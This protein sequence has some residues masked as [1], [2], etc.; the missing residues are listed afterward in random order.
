MSRFNTLK[1]PEVAKTTHTHQGGVGY[2]YKP[3]FELIALLSTGLGDK[4]YEK[5]DERVKRLIDIISQIKDK[6]FVAKALIYA[7]SVIGQRSVTHLGAVILAKY[8]SGTDLATRFF[9]KRTRK[10]NKGGVI[11]RLDDILEI[12]ACYTLLN[13]STKK[14]A[15][16]KLTVNLPNSMKKGFKKAL[17][18]ADE[19]ELARYQG[20][21]K[22]FSM[23][24]VVNLVHPTPSKEMAKVFKALMDGTLK[25]SNTVE[26]K[27]SATGQIV[28]TKLKTGEITKEEA[29]QELEEVKLDN[30]LELIRGRKI[31]YIALIR[32]L[33]NIIVNNPSKELINDTCTLLTDQKMIKQ[34]LI[35]PHQIDI[36]TEVLL[37]EF[38]PN[39]IK[40]LLEALN[41]AY[42]LAI[43]NLVELFQHG[44]TAVVIDTSGSM[45]GGATVK[46]GGKSINKE[47]IEK[48]ALIGATLAKGA[49][50]DLYQFSSTCADIK[51]NP[52]DTV[53]SIKNICLSRQGEV[54]H[55]TNFGEIFKR[56]GVTSGYDRIFIISDMQGGDSIVAGSD[57][58]N[59]NKKHGK[60]F[61][62]TIDIQGYGTTMFKQNSN[63]LVQL[64]GYSADIYEYIRKAE[65]N[66]QEIIDTINQIII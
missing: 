57:Y 29:D 14:R 48:A 52:L 39:K 20:K 22:T 12:I 41:K 21:G 50:A 42:E 3:E 51:Y 58:Q 44:K 16:G 28:A 4:Y 13:P 6:E 54:G 27:N 49:G 59:Y 8:I 38:A 35:F 36:A 18:A 33:R 9:S 11:Y 45:H 31:G 32:N 7:R 10:A 62:Y 53:N 65:L 61:I 56:L 47:P 23:I 37:Q 26:A 2:T 19:F 34:S 24:D 5:D 60:P 40:Q 64:F 55:S 1:E 43:P 66:P 25:Q 46:M 15:N 17:E 63:N 30:Y